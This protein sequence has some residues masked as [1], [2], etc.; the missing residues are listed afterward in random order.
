MKLKILKSSDYEGV[1]GFII[2]YC[3][4]LLTEL[5]L[6]MFKTSIKY[7]LIP[8]ER[9]IHNVCP[10]I[11]SGNKSDVTNY[12]SVFSQRPKKG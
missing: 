4:M 8:N 2:R 3:E 1:G 12:L 11:K 7:C 10:V 5:V 9:K 6:E